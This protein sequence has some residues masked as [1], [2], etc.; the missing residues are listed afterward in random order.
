MSR[1]VQK[2]IADLVKNHRVV[3]FM[4]GTQGF[5][6]CGFSAAAVDVLKK[7]TNDIKDVDVLADSEIRQ[8]VKEFSN[9]PTIPQVFVNGKFIG[10]S[11]ILRDLDA[12][13]ELRKILG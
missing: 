6:Q 2:E 3:I 1:D 11:D 9:W 12:S 5:P 8:G 7:Y 10:G 4:K 13:G